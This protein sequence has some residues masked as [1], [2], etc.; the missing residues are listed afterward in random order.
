MYCFKERGAEAHGTE[1]ANGYW[2]K[3]NYHFDFSVCAFDCGAVGSRLFL[4]VKSSRRF[5]LDDAP[6]SRQNNWRDSPEGNRTTANAAGKPGR[7]ALAQ[8]NN[9]LNDE[10]MLNLCNLTVL[11]GIWAHRVLNA[12]A[13]QW[14]GS[15]IFG[16]GEN[17]HSDWII[18]FASFLQRRATRTAG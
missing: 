7:K 13:I 14:R 11:R 17:N 3:W 9:K 8:I 15:S 18:Q 12:N 6:A 5:N 2:L 1:K 4:S 16:F 10:T